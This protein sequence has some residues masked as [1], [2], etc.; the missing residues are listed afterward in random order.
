MQLCTRG[1]AVPSGEV[2]TQVQTAEQSCESRTGGDKCAPTFCQILLEMQ[3][4]VEDC[5]AF[6][7]RGAVVGIRF[8]EPLT[9][10]PENENGLLEGGQRLPQ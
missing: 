4:R 2:W 7:L 1:V 6:T 10:E 8:R 3:N 5:H 9:P